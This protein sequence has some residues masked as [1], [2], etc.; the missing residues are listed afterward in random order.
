MASSRDSVALAIWRKLGEP[1]NVQ[2]IIDIGGTTLSVLIRWTVI[3][4]VLYPLATAGAKWID[5]DRGGTAALV[6]GL[7]DGTI[8]FKEATDAVTPAAPAD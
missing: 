3:F 7:R 6:D 2:R 4:M 5:Q 8:V 1:E